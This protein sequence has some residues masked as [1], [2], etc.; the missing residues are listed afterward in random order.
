MID[1]N[2]KVHPQNKVNQKELPQLN[3]YFTYFIKN[4][5]EP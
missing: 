3:K 1:R 4:E 5:T 2:F